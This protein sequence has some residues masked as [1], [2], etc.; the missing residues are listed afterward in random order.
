MVDAGIEHV[1]IPMIAMGVSA[2]FIFF[3][4]RIL[5]ISNKVLGLATALV[6]LSVGM[7]VLFE[8]Q[9][10]GMVNDPAF[11]QGEFH[12]KVFYQREPAAKLLSLL[13]FASGF[14]VSVYSAGYLDKEDRQHTFYPLL[15]LMMAGLVGM[16]YASD[17]LVLYLFL[18]LMSICAY[19]LVA[20]RRKND[21]AI[22]AGFKYLIM[23]SV[24]SVVMLSG[25]SILFLA[26]GTLHP[27]VISY[28]KGWLSQLGGLLM[29]TGFSL[30]SALVPLHTWLPDAH[31]KAPSSISAI[32]SGVLVQSVLYVM[33][34]VNL[35]LGF[36]QWLLGSIL[37]VLAVL[38]ILVGNLMG[39]VQVNLKRMLGYS[40]VAQIGYIT[41]CFAI[42]LRNGSLLALQS[43]FFI[44]ITH[45]LAKSLAFLSAGIFYHY[46]NVN[47]VKELRFLDKQPHFTIITMCIAIL[48][49]SA[50]PPFLGFTGKWTTLTSVFT[51]ND[52]LVVWVT[53]ALL[54]GSL[55][56][57]GY[58]LPLLINLLAR[59]QK[60][61]H[62]T[63]AIDARQKI[64]FWIAL[65][66][67]VLAALLLFFMVSPQ[68]LLDG[69]SA[70]AKFMMESIK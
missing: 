41:L 60:K 34:R 48:S 65:P 70:A 46:E 36:E 38:N 2:I 68:W 11:L 1:I 56:A 40:T 5:R 31:G 26:N 47:D 37:L 8:T 3:V 22:E 53:L 7:Y 69:T 19:A 55:I 42:G 52:P 44:I 24:A 15:L 51:A 23:G 18:E 50:L 64:S 62:D 49:L 21:A 33:I 20:F 39:T 9:L 25:V 12:E 57:F 58:Y 67:A 43:G 16:L 54:L 10:V 4:A 59:F 66:V 45:S 13:I 30:K 32:L 14:I 35:A 63:G 27:G 28:G 61:S 17:L 6:F 29:L